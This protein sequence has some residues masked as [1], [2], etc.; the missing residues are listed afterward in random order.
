MKQIIKHISPAL[1]LLALLGV[2]SCT[3]MDDYLKYTDGKEI[4]YTGIPD[5]IEMYSGYNRV[6]FRGLLASDPKIAKIKIYWNLKQDSLE[7]DIQRVGD[8]DVLEISIPLE[9]GTYNFEMHTYDKDGLHPSVPFNLTGTSY[10]DSYKNALTNRIVKKVE[11]TG[12]DVIIDWSPAEST[13]L[14]TILHYTDNTGTVRELTIENETEQTILQDFKSM[15]KFDIQ[16]FFLPDE[17]SIDIFETKKAYYGVSEDI[18]SLYL[19]N[20]QRPFAGRDKNGDNK[21]GIL[22][23]WDYTPNILNQSNG[24]GGWSDDWGNLSIHLESKDWGGDGIT[25]GKVYQSFELPAGNYLLECDLEGGSNGMNGYLTASKGTV[26]PDIDVL[27]ES[28]LGYNQYGDSNMG[29]IHKFEFTLPEASTVSVGWV[30]SFGSSTWMKV[31]YI[32][33]MNV[34]DSEE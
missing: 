21:W 17:T 27:K 6:V 15:T 34:A 1:L 19:K 2:T 16:T 22:V 12:N 31:K 23:D 24:K 32:K 3:K 28:S 13:A 10:G 18:T 4:L 26:L 9:E 5:L 25:N 11:K 7:Q 29:G 8:S 14:H 33:L 30:V 20:Y